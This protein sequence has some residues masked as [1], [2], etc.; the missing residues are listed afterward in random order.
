[1]HVPF[2]PLRPLSNFVKFWIGHSISLFGS[3]LAFPALQLTAAVLLGASPTQ[4]GLL[5][6]LGSLPSLLLG[7][8]AGAWIDRQKRRP[9]LVL[10]DLGRSLF[11]ILLT[12][13]ALLDTLQMTQLYVTAFMAGLLTLVSDVA[14]RAYLPSLVRHNQLL[15]A[16]SRFELSQSATE[17]LSPGLAGALIQLASVPFLLAVNAGSFLFSAALVTALPDLEPTPNSPLA[18]KHILQ[19]IMDGLHLVMTNRYLRALISNISTIG[20]FYSMLETVFLLHLAR[21]LR[22]APGLIGFVFAAGGLG[23]LLAARITQ[24]MTTRFGLGPTLMLALLV[25]GLGNLILAMTI[26][27]PITMLLILMGGYTLFGLGHTAYNITQVSLRQAIT[28]NPLQGRMNAT[29]DFALWG[30]APLGALLGGWLGEQ[31]GLRAVISIAALGVLLS[32]LW[33]YFSPVRTL[34][35]HPLPSHSPQAETKEERNTLPG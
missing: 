8:F 11:F 13:S 3:G 20:L 30:I 4:I 28:P 33:L 10:A 25:L 34:H 12:L 16:N 23:F 9:L 1:M 21:D 15:K 19:E 35:T 7:L 29:M 5:V 32:V 24:P 31:L 14:Y 2:F 22:L 27:S 18:R 6:A 17:T 26:G